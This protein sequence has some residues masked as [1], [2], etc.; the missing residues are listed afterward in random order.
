MRLLI[1]P[2][3]IASLLSGACNPNKSASIDIATDSATIAKGQMLFSQS[4][5]ACHDFM[6]DGIGPHLGGLTSKVSPEWIKN[7]IRN[8]Q[9]VVESGDE[10]GQKLFARYKTLMP[11]FPHYSEEEL[12]QIVAFLHTEATPEISS[13]AGEITA[14]LNPI[15]ETIPMSDVVAGVE[16]VTEFPRTG[17]DAFKTRITKLG[18]IPGTERL[19]MV[20]IRGKLYEL[21]DDGP[22]VY[23]DM[24][25][26]KPDFI[27]A[28]GLATGFG[29]F[30][31]H[32][33]FVTNGLLYTG[34]TEK[35]GAAKADFAYADSIPVAMQWVISEWKTDAPESFPFKGKSRELFRINMVS[36]AHGVQEFA[37]DPNA[38]PSEETYGLLHIGIGDG[39]SVQLGYPSVVGSNEN[40]L[41]A[42]FRIDPFGRNSPNKQYG[43]PPSNPFARHENP[44]VVKEIYAYGFR[45]PHRISWT[46]SGRM[47]VS[48]IGQ[49]NIESINLIVPGGNYGWPTREGTFLFDP[50]KDLNKVY[51]LPP[52]EATFDFKYPVAQYDHDEGLAVSGGFEY[53]GSLA[54]ELNGKYVFADMNNGRLF[55]IDVDE[56]RDGSIATIREWTITL[57]GKAITTA[58]LCG[59]QRVDLRLGKDYNGEIY[60]FSK[61]DGKL[62][63]LVGNE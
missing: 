21:Q 6:R 19:F 15:P 29:S 36:G 34:H 50:H 24:R 52:D 7:F 33:D 26:L 9:A 14:L 23:M 53:T 60:L 54:P 39:S 58:E 31:F 59:N 46:K 2:C 62:Y 47:L 10:R 56:V 48:N 1:T 44:K 51:P 20:D 4:C 27:D 28:P 37:F 8:P 35:A 55:Y 12:E 3:I 30:A 16:F 41:G 49:V 63:K 25:V 17:N 40:A 42:I 32:P 61:Q 57:N 18:F 43:I 38:A 22:K 45:N 13:D 5:S 11:S